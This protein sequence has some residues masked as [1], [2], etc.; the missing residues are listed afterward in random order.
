MSKDY[1]THIK[2]G[3][4]RLRNVL[5]KE[6]R[7]FIHKMQ[8]RS[9]SR[10][11]IHYMK[12]TRKVLASLTIASMVMTMVPFNAFA[13]TVLPTRLAG[14]TAAQT[15]VAIANQ[16]GW[17][18][19][20]AIL[21][22]SASYGMVDA[23]TSGPLATLLKAPILLQEPGTVL[24]ADTKAA[25]VNLKI[26]KVY[27]TSGTSVIS[28]EVLNQ[29]IAM[30]ITVESLGGNDRFDT[31]VK[32]A[33]KMIA[34][35]ATVSKVAVTYGWKCQDALS[36]ASI[37]SAATQPIIL[38]P[39]TGLT[40]SAKAFIDRN[41]GIKSADV[42]GGTG[43]I[44][45]TVLSQLTSA[46]RHA[47]I[48]AYDT[49]D[50]V[51]KDFAGSIQFNQV[52]L[53]NGVTGID[54]L[55]GAPLAAQNSSAIVLTDGV[56]APVAG[57]F[58]KTKMASD[59]VV[60]A[61]GGT[62]VVPEKLRTDLKPAPVAPAAVSSVSAIN[63]TVT[64]TF[65]K[66]PLVAPVAGDF[67]VTQSINGAAATT[68][69]PTVATAGVVSTLTIPAVV[70]TTVDQA[71]V[72]SVIYNGGTSKS[73]TA[74]TVAKTI[75]PQIAI[76]KAATDAVVAYEGA[77]VVTSADVTAA[78]ALEATATADVN[79]VTDA[80]VKA[81]LVAQIAVKK[82]AVEVVKKDLA[83]AALLVKVTAEVDHYTVLSKGDLS[84]QA[85][86]NEAK[87][88]GALARTD[89]VGLEGL[90]VYWTL[91]SD[92]QK[93]DT[94][95]NSLGDIVKPVIALN[96]GSPFTIKLGD[97]FTDPGTTV[98]DNV[99]QGL[100]AV[101]SGLVDTTIE[102]TY[103]L[104]YN[105]SDNA[106]NAAIPVT[107][108]VVVSAIVNPDAAAAK[109]VQDA[110]T[111]LPATITL[112]NKDAVVAAKTAYTDLTANQQAL[113]TNVATLT[114]AEATIAQLEAAAGMLVGEGFTGTLSKDALENTV[115]NVTVT[116]PDVIGVT[117]KNG[118]AVVNL[119][120][121]GTSNVW[122]IALVGTVPVTAADI[123]LKTAAALDAVDLTNSNASKGLFGDA[124]VVLTLKSGV[125]AS[126][127][128]VNG[129]TMTYDTTNNV[130][131]LDLSAY[132][133]TTKTVSVVV[134]TATGSQTLTLAV[135]N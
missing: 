128:K 20:T 71:V 70:A 66:A 118:A 8:K 135:G 80:S 64:A 87:N 74:F 102:G 7:S 40:D 130:Y 35:G 36:I 121:V 86:I 57:A 90:D 134:T 101:A 110:I 28:Q 51:I 27:V 89:L 34:E 106:G 88:A 1:A 26:K 132:D 16:T 97:T 48:T 54:A 133:T 120:R 131:Y 12:K 99:D 65:D 73:S 37:A 14:D 30:G 92:I 25:L 84:T 44:D 41:V 78:E 9:R 72:Y 62:F 77:P 3:E 50:Q 29:V 38:T 59:S 119:N 129:Q 79:K 81:G 31:S 19:D 22:S 123:T 15:A 94:I 6:Q 75:D 112:T 5:G 96:G 68:V 61:L 2:G 69:T 95:V 109:T 56:T 93:A 67:V 11:E 83:D 33:D 18:N 104:T 98:T 117:V 46:T 113:V 47:G 124:F 13:T 52:Y 105:V 21:A 100:V 60:T 76:V 45:D 122:K 32:I 91:L 58:V 63:G 108:N 127:V 115:V 53:A 24:N 55:S 125:T 39:K 17:T 82:T 126:T 103:I 4:G 85:L 116:A 43:V 42:I 107:R 10:G 114:A 111:A 23:L 49:N